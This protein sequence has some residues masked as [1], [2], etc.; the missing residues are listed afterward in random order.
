MTDSN[1]YQQTTIRSIGDL[2]ET[3]SE[4]V[5]TENLKF[6]YRGQSDSTWNLSPS[7]FRK[8]GST[9]EMKAEERDLMHTFRS[10]ASIRYERKPSFEDIA[11]WISL[12][13]H[14]GLP[15]RLL[16]W[17]R[18]PLV[19]SY[20]ALEEYLYDRT[21]D[22]KDACVWMLQ[23]QL[24]NKSQGFD[25]IT[26]T[27]DSGDCRHLIEPAFYHEAPESEKVQAVTSSEADIRMFVQ[28]GA[29]T[30]HSII[31]PIDRLQLPNGVLRKFV[32]PAECCI[33]F[34]YELAVAGFRKGDIYPDL[35]NLA[36]DL[37]LFGPQRL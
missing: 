1:H 15:T 33:R 6:W 23:P 34:S 31:E 32:I 9:L 3:V 12:M 37:N 29:F 19:A 8:P 2:I 17:S 28:Q 35:Q 7:V 16:D 27:I 21:A 36:A 11:G 18:S 5:K 20:F 22:H 25:E 4:I 10:R 30:I 14:Y 13:Q 24:L 26:L